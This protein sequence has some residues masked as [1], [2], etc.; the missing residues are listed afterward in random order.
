MKVYYEDNHVIVVEKEPN[1]PTQ[2][3]VSE[4]LDMVRILKAYLKEKY[5]KPGNVFVGLIHRLDRPVGGIMVFAK[6]S[7]AASRLSD[8]V[9]QNTIDKTYIAFVEG[10]VQTGV[11]RDHLLKNQKT[12][13]S[14]VVAKNHPKGKYAELHI[15]DTHYYSKENLTCVSISLITGRSHQIRVQF[16]SRNHPLWGDARYNPNAVPK[17]QIALWASQLS[18]NHPIT[19]ERLTF[20]SQTPS[21]Y[22]F[23]LL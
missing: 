4:D 15:T 20:T 3:D 13:T 16:A 6:T 1:I 17:E 9:R 2:E 11:Y 14:T 23:T 10:N 18:F 8:Q 22:P 5:Q 21:R 19:K 7:K 12:N